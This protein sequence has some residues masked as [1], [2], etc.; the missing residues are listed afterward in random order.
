VGI[1]QF[2]LSMIPR[3][4]LKE[5]PE[6]A[7]GAWSDE[8]LAAVEDEESG[9]W[10]GRQPTPAMV[11]ELRS[12]LPRDTSWGEVEEFRSEGTWGSDLRI[13]RDDAGRVWGIT[14]RFSPVADKPDV[15]LQYVAAAESEDCVL[16]DE[17]SGAVL[18][19]RAEQVL[20]HLQKSRAMRFMAA[21]K[22]AIL[23]A[24]AETAAELEKR[25]E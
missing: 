1:H 2:K 8:Q 6:F 23:E 15:L 18:E 19:P 16:Y 7:G 21:P 12:L 13:W 4:F 10:V 17:E 14:L 22:D 25:K 24:A 9:C 5:R 3:A 20:P 11:T